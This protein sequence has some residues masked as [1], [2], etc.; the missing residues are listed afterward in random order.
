MSFIVGFVIGAVAG[1]VAGF[2]VFR[3]NQ[4]K[5]NAAEANIKNTVDTI[6]NS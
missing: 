1:F 5:I 4:S 2:L 6:K 3:K